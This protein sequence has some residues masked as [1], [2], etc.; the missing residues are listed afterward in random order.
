MNTTYS[1]AIQAVSVRTAYATVELMGNMKSTKPA[2][3]RKTD[4]W[5]IKGRNS[6]AVD[7]PKVSTP[8]IAKARLP[9]RFAGFEERC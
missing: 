3:K 9:A 8:S 6:T 2:K 7:I 5:S 4:A 1:I